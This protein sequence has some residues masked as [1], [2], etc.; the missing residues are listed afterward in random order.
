MTRKTLMVCL[1][2]GLLALTAAVPVAARRDDWKDDRREDRR[3]ARRDDRADRSSRREESRRDGMSLDEAVA[4]VRRDTG[5][6]VLSAE[7]RDGR[8]RIKV[9]LPNGAVRVVNVDA[10]SGRMD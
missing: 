1:L 10:R 5:G 2:T 8:Y 7:A 6:R 4:R 9:L 3:E